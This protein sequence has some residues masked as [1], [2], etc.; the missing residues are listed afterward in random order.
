[1]TWIKENYGKLSLSVVSLIVAGISV[2]LILQSHSFEES[3]AGLNAT[4]VKGEKLPE[5]PFETLEKGLQSLAQP[6]EWFEPKGA[7]LFISDPYLVQETDGEQVLV[8][9]LQE[10][11]K[12]IH[13]PV[14]NK[15]FQDFELE[16]LNPNILAED[17][18]NDG[19]T[20][21]EE[22]EYKTNPRD[23][24]SI[25]PPHILLTIAGE[26]KKPVRLVFQ[27]VLGELFQV[28][29]LDTKPT[30]QNVQLGEMLKGT[31]F[32]VVSFE[33]KYEKRDIGG[34]QIEKNVSEL[35]IENTENNEKTALV[36]DV[37]TDVGESLAIF[38]VRGE[39]GEIRVKKNVEFTVRGSKYRLVKTDVD[40][41]TIIDLKNNQ[42]ILIPYDASETISQPQK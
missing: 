21:L 11:S 9:P 12:P 24:S 29:A 3:F 32:K 18:D 36:K 40:G 14:P 5:L 17:T 33:E 37:I 7:S 27:T 16:I 39:K 8:N 34:S 2:W 42:R 35:V 15:W 25:P 30:T 13:P 10:G 28:R 6:S 19:F 41:A 22:W 23:A 38:R 26:E 20:N 1:M 4:T 31:K